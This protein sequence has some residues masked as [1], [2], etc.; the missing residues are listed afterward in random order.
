MFNLNQ[1]FGVFIFSLLIIQSIQAQ[2]APEREWTIFRKGVDDYQAGKYSD[3]EKNFSTMI[4]KLP[5][6]KLITANYL[7]LA[8]TQYKLGKYNESINTCETFI[9]NFQE[10]AYLDEIY[11]L[12]GNNNY[13]MKYYE[14]AVHFWLTAASKKQSISKKALKLA[15]QTTR[16]KLNERQLTNLKNNTTDPYAR[17]FFM[18]HLAEKYYDKGNAASAL[19]TLEELRMS[20]AKN[21]VYTSETQRL[22]DILKNRK[23]NSIR[24]AALLP[25]SG[26]NERIGQQVLDG[27]NMAAENFNKLPGID[28]EIVPYD[29]GSKLITAVQQLKEIAIDRSLIAVFGPIEN[30]ITI[31]CAAIA[32]YEKIPMISPTS[33]ENKLTELSPNVVQLATPINVIS[34]N[35]VH[36]LSDSLIAKRAVTLAPIDDYFIELT[37]AF[38]N[39]LQEIGGE[40]VSEQWY[41]PGDKDFSK[42]FRQ[43]KRIGLKLAFQDSLY[44]LDPTVSPALIDSMYI[45]Y[46]EEKKKLLEETNTKIDSADIPVTSFDAIFLPIYTEDISLIAPQFALSNIQAQILGNSDWYDPET[47]KKNRSYINGLIFISDGYIDEENWDY[48]QFRNNFRTKYQRTPEKFDLIGYDCFHLIIN[49]VSDNKAGI[50]RENFVDTISNSSPYK[51]I[52]RHFKMDNSRFNKSTRLLKYWRG[53][54]VPLN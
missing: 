14:N 39:N 25:L 19:I 28:L 42:Q 35:L 38:V 51:G 12:I 22:Y 27:A 30:D 52:Y 41:Y 15:E 49:L 47:L 36:Q 11:Y 16:Y 48:R 54:L 10:S 45:N 13:K 9:S 5:N 31:A 17:I 33:S 4:A 29:Y 24:I 32:E 50:N 6:S 3:A 40:I 21:I 53:V 37:D 1:V 46:I 20:P 26:E 7:M 23:S 18:Y 34:E 44:E 43:L 8:K 2:K